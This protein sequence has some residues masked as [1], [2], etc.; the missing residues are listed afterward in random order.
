M[1]FF[2]S[3]RS[4][5]K[6]KSSDSQSEVSRL[7][8]LSNFQA[9]SNGGTA[10]RG[11]F[12]SV[13]IVGESFYAPA[14]KT[15][16]EQLGLSPGDEASLEVELI[17][18][19]DNP[20]EPSGKAVGVFV[21]GQKVG[22]VSSYTCQLVFDELAGVN[23]RKKFQGRIYFGDLRE[24]P[25]K[26]SVSIDY[27]IQT[28]SADEALK[29]EAKYQREQ[30][31]R[32]QAEEVKTEFLMAPVWSTHTLV[33]GDAV[34]FTGFANYYDLPKLVSHYLPSEPSTGIHLLVIHPSMLPDSA[35]L[36]E[37]LRRERPVTDLVT[38]LDNNPNFA[39]HFNP[40]TGSF[41]VPKSFRGKKT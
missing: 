13:E 16:R 37:W 12:E 41:E 1:G 23:G 3:F 39:Q 27:S 33:D 15:L 40:S 20:N 25:P 7:E 21:K 10:Q 32:R 9:P 34:T 11:I 38:F 26:N 5:N 29:S 35:K 17:N 19:P 6:D 22:H 18:D 28:K 4:K 14:F 31:K 36:R 2:D 24:N 8:R 30:E